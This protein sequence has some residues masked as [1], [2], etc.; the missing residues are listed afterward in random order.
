VVISAAL[1]DLELDPAF[2]GRLLDDGMAALAGFQFDALDGVGLQ[3][4]VQ[5]GL[6]ALDPAVVVVMDLAAERVEDG[7]VCPA[8]QLDDKAGGF[9]AEE[10]GGAVDRLGQAE[11]AAGSGHAGRIMDLGANRDDVG[12][13]Q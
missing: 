7:R 10:L 6:R 8:G 13:A 1:Q 3:K 12:H 11:P 9:A 5:L 2:G 4:A